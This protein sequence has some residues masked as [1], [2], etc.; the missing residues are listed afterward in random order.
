MKIVRTKILKSLVAQLP[1]KERTF[2]FLM[3]HFGNELK[4]L[5]KLFY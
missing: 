3:G 5:K 4:V 2:F 1:E